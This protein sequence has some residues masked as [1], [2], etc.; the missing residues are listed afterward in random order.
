MRTG[1]VG[2]K[3]VSDG[4][5]T[6]VS[7]YPKL[8]PVS[9]AISETVTRRSFSIMHLT[10]WMFPLVKLIRGRQLS[11]SIPTPFSVLHKLLVPIIHLEFLQ[12]TITELRLKSIQNFRKFYGLMSQNCNVKLLRNTR[13]SLANS[14][15]RQYR[16]T[17][18]NRLNEH[19]LITWHTQLRHTEAPTSFRTRRVH[20]TKILVYMIH[21]RIL[22][23]LKFITE[24]KCNFLKLTIYPAA[25]SC[26]HYV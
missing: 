2:K 12:A 10:T 3:N 5:T 16:E 15:W 25:V 19:W 24:N 6:M 4:E 18:K 20:Q 13:V 26:F 11:G 22:E 8:I 21:P 14:S 7:E 23:L 9:D 17:S 1:C